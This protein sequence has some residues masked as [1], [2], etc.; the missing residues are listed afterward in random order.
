MT[1]ATASSTAVERRRLVFVVTE[2]WFF[3]SHFLPMARAAIAMGL[4]VAVVTR[5]NAHAEAIRATGAR[6]IPLQAERASFNPVSLVHQVRALTAILRAERPD[7]VHAIALRSIVVAGIARRMAGVPCVVHALT[8]LG[9]LGAQ[10]GVAA[11]LVRLAVRRAVT[12]PLAGPGS[13]F[14]F[15]NPDDPATLGLDPTDASRVTIVGGAGVD[16]DALIPAPLP[17][18]PPP[19]RVALVARMLWSKGIDLAVEAVTRARGAG[20]DVT[21]SLY[22]AP[23]PAN[24]KAVPEATLREWSARPGI[25]WRGPTKDIAGVWAWHHVAILPSRG[26]EGL[27]RTILE[28]AACGRAIV[29]TDVPGCRTFVRDGIEGH[30]VPSGDAE[31]LAKVL[32][33][34]AADPVRIAAMGAAARARL[35]DGHTEADVMA[36]V[37]RLY[38][39][40]LREPA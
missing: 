32:V 29:T 20:A 5:V 30:V 13:R 22:G 26:G 39:A 11:S 4:D 33:A 38:A 3:V 28:A 10:G 17:A 1:A 34:L 36:A 9:F 31:A 25:E 8:G 35:L 16:P 24:P 37:Q 27:P 19:L 15:E 23:D 18:M 12:G 40:C 14:L 21:L 6:V 2:D 7:I